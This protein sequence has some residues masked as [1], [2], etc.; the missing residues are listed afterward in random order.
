MKLPLRASGDHHPCWG[1]VGVPGGVVP[2]LLAF[3]PQKPG[4]ERKAYD[5]A[6]CV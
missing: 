2:L 6:P 5:V 3:S 1:P 4:F